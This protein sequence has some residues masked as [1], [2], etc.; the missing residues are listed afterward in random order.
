VSRQLGALERELGAS[1]LVRT[2]RRISLT[3][4]GRQFYEHCVRV[5]RELEA[6]RAA[7]TPGARGLVVVSAPVTY[8]LT[9]ISP[10]LPALLAAHPGLEVELRLEDRVV[11][12]LGEG[13]DLAVRAG[14]SPPDS[15]ALVARRLGA[16]QRRLVA[17]PAY[18]RTRGTP[19]RPEELAR[20]EALVHL[21]GVGEAGL[22]LFRRDGEEHRIRVRGALRSNAYLALHQAALAGRGVAL[23][24]DLMVADDLRQRRLRVLLP[25]YEAPGT[26]VWALFRVELRGSGRLRAVLADLEAGLA[27]ASAPP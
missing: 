22:W 13:V 9:T 1:L 21:P 26:S 19:R 8:G 11:D 27:Q 20:H 3:S 15:D 16:W 18:L 24:P 23:L 5:G 14:A 12:L 7:V 17:A 25:A 4:A 6:A 10:R 2:T